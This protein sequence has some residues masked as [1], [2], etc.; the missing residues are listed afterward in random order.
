M[1]R[2]LAA[3]AAGLALA[4]A[5]YA[6]AQNQGFEVPPNPFSPARLE[7][8]AAP[9]KG[10]TPVTD[11]ML[12]KPPPGDWLN[13]RRTYDGW[14]YSPLA[15]INTKNARNLRLAWAWALPAGP[16]ESTPIVHDGVIFIQ[17]YG[18][19][20]EALNAA[21]G[22]LL[23]R[24]VRPLPRGTATMFK[25]MIAIHGEQILLSTSDKHLVALD[26]RT[27]KPNWDVKV[28]GAGT[29]TNG[30][31]IAD[32]KLVIGHSFCQASRCAI[33]GHDLKDG[34]EL[35]RFWTV[36][37]PGEPGGDTWN[38]V[39]VEKRYGGSTWT[40]GSYDPDRKLMYWGIGQPYAWNA[41]ARGTSPLKPGLSNEALY[42]NNTV[43]LDPATGKVA[44]HFS[45]LPNDSWDL[46]YVF[47]RQII[48]LPGRDGQTKPLVVTAGKMAIIEALDQ[49]TGRFEWAKDLGLQ[50][51]VTA[52]DPVTGEK[53]IDPTKIPELNK[54]VS[55]CPHP[56]GARSIGS[57]AYSPQ[58]G[59]LYLPLQEHCTDMTPYPP[60]N[61]S[62]I[63][64]TKFILKPRPDSDG[65][66]GR[67]EAVDLKTRKTAWKFRERAPQSTAALPTGGGLVFQGAYDRTFKAHDARTGKVLWSTRLNDVPNNYPVTFM[68]NGKQY[69]AVASGSGSPYTNTWRNLVPELR[70]PPASGATLWVFEVP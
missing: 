32:G 68:A 49:Q 46:D 53:T 48:S 26:M 36:A 30:P 20:V 31:M 13:W 54:T 40:T 56:G 6:A 69:V 18:D 33:T 34:K 19:G 52:I 21:T 14:G 28:E 27:G 63:A 25:R 62:P 8:V 60:E 38:D 11:E 43:A 58:T 51:L 70:F 17:G 45:H 35:W 57:T 61:D 37:G 7:A 42:T 66:I 59:M 15:Q 5:G 9:L 29:F 55:F 12:A 1:R 41:F 10:L 39:P 24:Y 50:D 22:D 47:E 2:M 23:W 67:L 44:W 4:S 64:S 3:A 16:I 65:N